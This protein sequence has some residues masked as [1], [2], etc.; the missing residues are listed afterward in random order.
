MERHAK[1]D[2]YQYLPRVI[3]RAENDHVVMLA[4]LFGAAPPSLGLIDDLKYLAARLREVWPDVH[5]SLRADSGFATP[6]VY[7]GCEDLGIRYTIGLKVA[8][9]IVVNVR[10]VRVRLSGSWPF[11]VTI[12]AQYPKPSTPPAHASGEPMR[13]S[14]PIA[15]SVHENST[16]ALPRLYDVGGKGA[17][18]AAADFLR[19]FPT[20]NPRIRW[21]IRDWQPK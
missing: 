2:Q 4:L 6:H 21:P 17:F 5:I 16:R 7:N 12:T 1:Y 11:L 20:L 9:E 19:H 3:T 8:A 13:V 14:L 10:R 18:R 15:D